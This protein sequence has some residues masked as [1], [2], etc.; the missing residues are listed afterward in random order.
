MP[1]KSHR[2]RDKPKVVTKPAA[3]SPY[4]R[5]NRDDSIGVG[6][7]HGT[8]DRATAV[9]LLLHY[10]REMKRRVSSESLDAISDLVDRSVYLSHRLKLINAPLERYSYER[11]DDDDLPPRR[12]P[13]I[14]G[15]ALRVARPAL[16]FSLREKRPAMTFAGGYRLHDPHSL[17]PGGRLDFLFWGVVMNEGRVEPVD[18]LTDSQV[19]EVTSAVIRNLEAWE[20]YIVE[21]LTDGPVSDSN[22]RPPVAEIN[23]TTDPGA[24]DLIQSMPRE[25]VSALSHL[26]SMHPRRQTN[27]QIAVAIERSE[28][29]VGLAVKGLIMA[30]LVDRGHGQRSG[31]GLTVRGHQVALRLPCG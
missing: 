2:H 28:R 21:G 16:S 29:T 3:S 18:L 1:R 27:I 7:D 10:V 14:N 23:R 5:E 12:G 24:D 25:Q 20:R 8:T 11:D 13:F 4:D 6:Y 19:S 31:A 15:I 17:H 9:R 30:R 22:Q 26:L